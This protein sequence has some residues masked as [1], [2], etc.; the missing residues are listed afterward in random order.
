MGGL[1][2]MDGQNVGRI[3]R[4]EINS[5]VCTLLNLSQGLEVTMKELF[6][7]DWEE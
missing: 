1:I 5:G 6:D 2:N 7:F 3:E 4:G